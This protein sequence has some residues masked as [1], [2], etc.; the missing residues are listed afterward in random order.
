[1][2]Q[3]FQEEKEEESKAEEDGIIEPLAKTHP[4]LLIERLQK[5]GGDNSS[6]E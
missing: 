3:Q 1:L 2:A 4:G 5:R 6:E